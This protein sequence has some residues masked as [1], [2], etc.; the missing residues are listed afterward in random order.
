MCPEKLTLMNS[1]VSDLR[2][3]AKTYSTPRG[4]SKLPGIENTLLMGIFF[5]KITLV[6]WKKNYFLKG[7]KLQ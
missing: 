7:E 6:R 3:G 2:Q 1:F 5:P 4:H